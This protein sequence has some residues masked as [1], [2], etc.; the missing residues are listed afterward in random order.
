MFQEM[1]EVERKRRAVEGQGKGPPLLER[2]AQRKEKLRG[3]DEGQKSAGLPSRRALGEKRTRMGFE[4]S[5]ASWN[6]RGSKILLRKQTFSVL[7]TIYTDLII[8]FIM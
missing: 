6:G 8:L 3:I 5:S 1:E 2:L 7:Y 4:G